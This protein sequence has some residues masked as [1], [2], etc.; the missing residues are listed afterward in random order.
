MTWSLWRDSS[1]LRTRKKWSIWKKK[2]GCELGRVGSLLVFFFLFFFFF[3][4][5]V[6]RVPEPGIP[7]GV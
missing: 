6:L 7:A 3:S 5:G 4:S 1:R 2:G